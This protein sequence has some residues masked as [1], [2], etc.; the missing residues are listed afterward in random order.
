[1]YL[2]FYEK[3]MMK[4]RAELISLFMVDTFRRIFVECVLPLAM[5]YIEGRGN[6]SALETKK[7]QDK[8][9]ADQSS[10]N[11]I[12]IMIELEKDHYEIFDDYLEMVIQLGYLT[13]FASAFP[14]ASFVA[15]GANMI[16][17]RS[18]IFKLTTICRKPRVLKTENIGTWN[19]LISCIIWLSALTN[20]FLFGYS[21]KQMMEFFPSFYVVDVEGEQHFAS[22]KGGFVVLLV[23]LIERIL[24]FVGMAICA[25]IGEI[26]ED[27]TLKLDK[28]AFLKRER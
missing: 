5:K 15:I 18:D 28:L 3:E 10:M 22:N 17:F 23:F 13:L 1:L 25:C 20:C 21:S 9:E 4:L 19:L 11:H 7:K 16:E 2:A 24:L 6:Q 26:P 27:V 12:E 8:T 14:L